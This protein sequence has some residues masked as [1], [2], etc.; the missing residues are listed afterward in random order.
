MRTIGSGNLENILYIA[1]H[2]MIIYK[3]AKFVK[4]LSKIAQQRVR[5]NAI[6]NINP[7][8]SFEDTM[9]FLNENL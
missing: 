8:D 2:D 1:N 7:M 4:N 6:I 5:G 9:E 3:M